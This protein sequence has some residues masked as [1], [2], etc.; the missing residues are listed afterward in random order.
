MSIAG[1]LEI[2]AECDVT[3]VLILLLL[4]VGYSL[5]CLWNNFINTGAV[6]VLQDTVFVQLLSV[7]S[8]DKNF[9]KCFS[10]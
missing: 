10:V 7:L 9:V 8:H 4:Q 3:I 1:Y 5:L 2:L 6:E